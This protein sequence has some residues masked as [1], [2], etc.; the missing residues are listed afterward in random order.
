MGYE[1]GGDE[2]TMTNQDETTEETE[3][4]LKEAFGNKIAIGYTLDEKE[5]KFLAKKKD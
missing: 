1:E 3:E 4:L 2:D 5:M